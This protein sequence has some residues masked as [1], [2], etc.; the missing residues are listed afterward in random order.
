MPYI[1]YDIKYV[2]SYFQIL[3]LNLSTSVLF[4]LSAS[5]EASC[6][7]YITYIFDFEFQFYL[8]LRILQTFVKY[9]YILSFEAYDIL[10]FE[11]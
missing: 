9:T 5:I 8:K 10:E 1:S 3:T 6:R 7:E 11:Y 2:I 4:I